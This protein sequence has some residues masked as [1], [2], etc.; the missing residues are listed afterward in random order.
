MGVNNIFKS[1]YNYVT[2]TGTETLTNKTIDGDLNTVQDLAYS[3]IKSDSRTG[4]DA[5]LVTGTA[6]TSTN[7]LYWNGDGDAVSSTG[8]SWT[9][10]ATNCNTASATPVFALAAPGVYIFTT[11]YAANEAS[12]PYCETALISAD[13]TTRSNVTILQNGSAVTI[14]MS[15]LNVTITQTSGVTLTMQWS[16]IRLI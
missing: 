4:A 11:Y 9:R 6:G 3:S 10:D 2:K 7:I 14:G 5:K 12:N 1:L 8:L 13:G 16:C 15:N